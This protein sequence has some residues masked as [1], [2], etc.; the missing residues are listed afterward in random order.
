MK[1]GIHP[2][3]GPA[4]V[5]CACG[6][7]FTTRATVSTIRADICS[8]CHPFYTGRQKI[9]DT[10]GRVERFHQ[11]YERYQQ[12]QRAKA[13]RGKAPPKKAAVKAAA[14]PAVKKTAKK[15]APQPKPETAE[16]APEG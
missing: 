5:T 8:K 13:E 9:V 15:T 16:T 10:A 3:Y 4:E 12:A 1:E 2:K 7:A 6:N 14:R 11:R